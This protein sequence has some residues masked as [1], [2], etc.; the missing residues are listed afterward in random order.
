MVRPLKVLQSPV[1]ELCNLYNC[2]RSEAMT[3]KKRLQLK[4]TLKIT[5]SK[6]VTIPQV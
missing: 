4:A 5:A 3:A 1:N 6:K 2:E